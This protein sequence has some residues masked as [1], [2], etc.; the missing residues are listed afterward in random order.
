MQVVTESFLRLIHPDDRDM[1]TKYHISRLQGE[2]APNVYSFRIV[3][4][5]GDVKWL[6]VNSILINWEGKPAVL[7]FLSDITERKQ[8]E[9][10]LR[11]SEEF[12]RALIEHSPIGISVR[13]RRFW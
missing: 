1:V 8:A 3:D 13:S 6:R 4:K 7:T 10:A 2:Q 12:N 5:V 9:V 11:K